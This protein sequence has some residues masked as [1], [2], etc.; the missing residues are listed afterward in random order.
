[1]GILA[2]LSQENCSL[3][4]SLIITQTHLRSESLPWIFLFTRVCVCVN[5][6]LPPF[7][8]A[9]HPEL[10]AP[11]SRSQNP[12]A[13]VKTFIT[14]WDGMICTTVWKRSKTPCECSWVP[15]LVI[16]PVARREPFSSLTK[17]PGNLIIKA[18][19]H[20]LHKLWNI[21]TLNTHV[22]LYF[23]IAAKHKIKQACIVWL[24]VVAGAELA[25]IQSYSNCY[26]PHILHFWAIWGHRLH[27]Q[28]YV[29]RPLLRSMFAM[30]GCY[31]RK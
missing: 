1:M 27:C 17:R 8:P 2:H 5:H 26:L 29:Q 13:R 4:S 6:I 20:L 30:D 16:N 9:V 3:N 25:E 11:C 7:S 21:C 19:Q 10:W 23:M 12:G 14:E 22:E 15:C 18:E 24:R 28:R 31:R